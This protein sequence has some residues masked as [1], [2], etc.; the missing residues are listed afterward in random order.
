MTR[1]P[2][3]LFW[4][5]KNRSFQHIVKTVKLAVWAVS[6]IF[7]A[8]FH[9]VCDRYTSDYAHFTFSDTI[10][11]LSPIFRTHNMTLAETASYS[12]WAFKPVYTKAFK[13]CDYKVNIEG[14][15]ILLQRILLQDIG[16]LLYIVWETLRNVST[17][18]FDQRI[19]SEHNCAWIKTY[20][21]VFKSSNDS[22]I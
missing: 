6:L 19:A 21:A 22:A 15:I 17:D 20:G 11:P 12:F 5:A 13:H 14:L 7:S 1:S 9:I 16:K 3:E 8:G 2:I 10:W 18:Y 4:T